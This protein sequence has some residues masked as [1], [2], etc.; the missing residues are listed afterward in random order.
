MSPLRAFL[1]QVFAELSTDVQVITYRDFVD[2][3]D[4]PCDEVGF[5]VP[6]YMGPPAELEVFTK[7]PNLQVVQLLTAGYDHARQYI[8]SGVT[9][10]NAAGVHDAST[11]ELAVGLIIA[12]QRGIDD[13][14][15]AMPEGIWLHSVRPSL[16]DRRVLIIG[17]GGLGT[18]IRDRLAPFEVEI[19]TVARSER[20]GVSSLTALPE[21][22][23]WAEIVI[24][25]VPLSEETRGMADATFLGQMSD[26]ALLVNMA[27]G[28]VVDTEA[29]VD[30]VS[31]GRIRA[32]L[33]VT[34]P[35][36]LPQS[37][38]LWQLPGV[39]ISPHVGGA[40][41]AFMPRAQSMV[42]KQLNRWA[43]GVPLH[44]VVNGEQPNKVTS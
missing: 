42:T 36:P 5:V 23:P 17:A 40:S 27:R 12:S 35:E 13:Y 14:A 41:T 15:K 44:N 1:P 21:L 22:L 33:D 26:S 10:C 16:A 25:A 34:D 20:E 39:L 9:L 18:A 8:P 19:A 3:D 2:L 28:P 4:V 38:P 24:L 31:S 32:A 37:H 43:S 7:F 6:P 11:A 29:L 30:Q